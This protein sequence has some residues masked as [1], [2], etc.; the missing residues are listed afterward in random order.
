M[1]WLDRRLQEQGK[2]FLLTEV[3]MVEKVV[4]P[5]GEGHFLKERMRTLILWRAISKVSP[6]QQ[7]ST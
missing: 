7:G 2:K 4:A 3:P 1:Y 6:I 5:G